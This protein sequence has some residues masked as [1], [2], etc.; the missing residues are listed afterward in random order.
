MSKEDYINEYKNEHPDTTLTDE[1]IYATADD[2]YSGVEE[3]GIY[4]Y[5]N[6]NVEG[7][8][9]PVNIVVNE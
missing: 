1:Q 7:F 8:V 4:D 9:K 3:D 5:Y 6:P 2:M